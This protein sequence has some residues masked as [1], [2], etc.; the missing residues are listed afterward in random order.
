[1]EL[2]VKSILKDEHL[3]IR[4]HEQEKILNNEIQEINFTFD[5]AGEYVLEIESVETTD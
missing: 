1:M 5:D 4:F 3:K 2:K